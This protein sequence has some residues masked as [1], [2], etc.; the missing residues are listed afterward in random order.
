[1]VN[2]FIK[3]GPQCIMG[4]KAKADDMFCKLILFLHL[5]NLVAESG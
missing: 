3:P 5:C 2:L 1:M 4:F